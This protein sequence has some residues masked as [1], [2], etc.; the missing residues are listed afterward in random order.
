[1]KTWCIVSHEKTCVAAVKLRLCGANR[2]QL[3]NLREFKA[4][5]YWIIC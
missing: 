3:L 2:V 1:M 5:S 4:K